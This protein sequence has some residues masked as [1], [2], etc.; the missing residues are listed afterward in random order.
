MNAE[1]TESDADNE[2][3]TSGPI[4]TN[5]IGHRIRETSDRIGGR[6]QLAK[7]AGMSDAQL[8][9]IMSEGSAP[10]IETV[11]AIARGAGV[12][13]EWLATGEGPMEADAARAGRS[14]PSTA[15][16]IDRER[17]QRSIETAAAI[18][19]RTGRAMEAAKQAEFILA[20]YDFYAQG[21]VSDEA[22]DN[23]VR[24]FES[25]N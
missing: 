24:L 11:A 16:T 3:R 13:L 2:N 14:A 20:L 18:L 12:S 7:I 6:K 15:D 25:A 10:K 4:L 23:I 22:Q 5:G 8:Y 9:R 1:T 21:D 19:Q 17:L